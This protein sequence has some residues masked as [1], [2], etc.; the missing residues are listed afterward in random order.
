VAEEK[1]QDVLGLFGKPWL[2]LWRYLWGEPLSTKKGCSTTMG[3]IG[4][5]STQ[6]VEGW[7]KAMWLN[8]NNLDISF[9]SFI[10][11][12]TTGIN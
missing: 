7:W 3:V 10:A 6:M 8:H 1:C 4:G 11:F 9:D 5:G 12:K 2:G